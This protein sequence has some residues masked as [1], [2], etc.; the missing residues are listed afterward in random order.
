MKPGGKKLISTGILTLVFAILFVGLRSIPVSECRFLHY[1]PVE[2]VIEGVEPELCSV[3]PVPFVDVVAKPFP[4]ELDIHAITPMTNGEVEILFSVLA[5]DGTPLLPHE[6]AMTHTKRI[7]FMLIDEKLDSYHHLHPEPLGDSGDYR[8]RFTPRS[9][10]YRY[11]AEFVPLQT[12]LLAVADGSLN[13]DRAVP[14]APASPSP[15]EFSLDGVSNPL[16]AN[17]DHRLTLRLRNGDDNGALPLEKTMDAYAHLVGFED[18]LS[19]YAHMHP[20]TVDP[21]IGET[22]EM[23]FVFHPTRPGNFRIWVQVRA[24]GNDIFEPFDVVVL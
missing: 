6:L 19:G 17:R 15:I 14:A 4:V 3:A 18:S 20:L 8:V 11:F 13:V 1:E 10:Q 16:Q 2:N 24:D 9:D 21:Y 7:H 5:P 23:E 22:A 12:R